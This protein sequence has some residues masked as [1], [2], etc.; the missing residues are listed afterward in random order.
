MADLFIG[1][2]VLVLI[3]AAA[4][5]HDL[6][7]QFA[8]ASEGTQTPPERKEEFKRRFLE[9]FASRGTDT[10]LITKEEF[11]AVN[12]RF[13]ESLLFGKCV[14]DPSPRGQR[15]L[16]D[17]RDLLS[18]FASDIE[19]VEVTGHTDPD[20]PSPTGLCAVQ[21]I[22]TNWQLSA[23]RAISVVEVLAPEDGSALQPAKIWAAALASYHPIDP[24][25]NLYDEKVKSS[26][27]RIEVLIK[28]YEAEVRRDSD[29][30]SSR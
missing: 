22:E 12:L 23:R 16:E 2:L 27:R 20:P 26:N 11:A 14:V 1:F 29:A 3:V 6:A 28:F 18:E 13:P 15:M 4:S 9:D 25:A 10:P 21:R 24:A 30:D 7:R 5:V 19:R 8:E 17:L